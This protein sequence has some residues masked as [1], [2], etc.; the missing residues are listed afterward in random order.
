LELYED[1][2]YSYINDNTFPLVREEEKYYHQ[3]CNATIIQD[4]DRC[5]FLYSINNI[6][7][8]KALFLPV[9]VSKEI[10][11][12]K[13]GFLLSKI[14]RR[15]VKII[16]YFGRIDDHRRSFEIAEGFSLLD[17]ND[18]ILV[19]NGEA[20]NEYI[21]KILKLS[22]NIFHFDKSQEIFIDSII[23]DAYIGIVPYE[24]KSTNDELT[25]FAS[26]KLAYYLKHKK[27]IIAFSNFQY[28]NFFNEYK[29]GISIKNSTELWDAILTIEANYS[30]F[31]RAA[32]QAFEKYYCFE[33]RFDLLYNEIESIVSG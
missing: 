22:S 16:L 33:N 6:K 7:N 18:F 10:P 15:D 8:Q 24:Y 4:P 3:K 13:P 1:G 21:S 26:E 20:N 28:E 27:P 23:S 9:S 5:D 25:V 30:S 19:L 11:V 17:S 32:N 12:L 29:C 2:H 14:N 31:Q